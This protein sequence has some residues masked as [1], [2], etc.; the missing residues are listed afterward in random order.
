MSDN[1]KSW[2]IGEDWL[3]QTT[4]GTA[5]A[6]RPALTPPPV[7]RIILPGAIPNS[8]EHGEVPAN[9]QPRCDV[10]NAIPAMQPIPLE[11]IVTHIERTEEEP[12]TNWYRFLS[13][14]ILVIFTLP[15]LLT[16]VIVSL[17]LA[18]A[19][20]ILGFSSLASIFNPVS[21][22]TLLFE[23]L[24]VV[25]LGRLQRSSQHTV[26]RGLVEDTESRRFNFYLHGALRTGILVEGHR[27]RLF[28]DW[29]RENRRD[30]NEVGTLFVGQGQDLTTGSTLSVGGNAWRPVF[31]ILLVFFVATGV[32]I[33][34]NLPGFSQEVSNYL[35]SLFR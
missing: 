11:G 35:H 32:T 22:L 13:Q 6:A 3:K 7:D 19:F 12:P 18:I 5:A 1:N 24:E 27:V 28:G 10:T 26:Y 23:I 17:V 21:W 31:F 20:A 9:P 25:V 4:G 34:L 14:T 16:P 30:A 8:P 15:I 29:R 33:A 2:N